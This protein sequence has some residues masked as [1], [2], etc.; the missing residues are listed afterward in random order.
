MTKKFQS[1]NLVIESDQKLVINVFG[2][3]PKNL[4]NNKKNSIIGSMA[5]INPTN[6]FFGQHTIFFNKPT[7]FNQQLW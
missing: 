5:I 1:P 7:K 4:G 6:K 2:S 3:C